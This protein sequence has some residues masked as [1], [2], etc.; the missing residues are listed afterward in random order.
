MSKFDQVGVEEDTTII[1]TKEMQFDGIDCR[2]EHW[3]FDGIIGQ[4]LIFVTD[5]IADKDTDDIVADLRQ[6]GLIKEGSVTTKE[7][8]GY[9]LLNFNFE[10]AEDQE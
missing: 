2:F 1:L 8:N 10:V 4:T 6:S 3:T 7:S 9:T 5:E